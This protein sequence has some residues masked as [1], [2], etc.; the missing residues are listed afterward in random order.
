MEGGCLCPKS[1]PIEK[2]YKKSTVQAAVW[3]IDSCLYVTH[4]YYVHVSE[5]DD[6]PK[7]LKLYLSM[8]VQLTF[9][10]SQL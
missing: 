10:N 3:R 5:N 1:C 2:S 6:G 8:F 9:I 4:V 7:N